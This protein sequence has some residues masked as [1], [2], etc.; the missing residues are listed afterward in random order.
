MTDQAATEATSFEVA[1]AGTFGPMLRAVFAAMGVQRIRTTSDF[2][3]RAGEGEGI[4]EIMEALE[5]RGLMVLEV[6]PARPAPDV[7]ARFIPSG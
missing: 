4:S 5:S 3:V 1:L 7:V 6:R 2:V